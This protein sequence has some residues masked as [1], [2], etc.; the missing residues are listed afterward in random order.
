MRG[1]LSEFNLRASEQWVV[2]FSCI[3]GFHIVFSQNIKLED[4]RFKNDKN[5]EHMRT[6]R[7]TG[8]DERTDKINKFNKSY[9]LEIC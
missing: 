2:K 4:H 9:F 6:E 8:M 7:L 3:I 5:I 1:S